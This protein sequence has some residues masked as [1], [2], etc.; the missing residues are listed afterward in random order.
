MYRIFVL[1]IY[2]VSL[3]PLNAQGLWETGAVKGIWCSP[4]KPIPTMDWKAQW[5]WLSE[6]SPMMLSRKSFE[7]REP[8]RKAVLKITATS[9][10]KL[11]INGQYIIKGPARSAPHHQSFDQLD[12]SRLL[13][14]QRTSK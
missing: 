7:L 6:E 12:I 5:I 11:Y 9:Q 13:E 1:L 4:E 14:F 3:P 10:Y 2:F 8:P